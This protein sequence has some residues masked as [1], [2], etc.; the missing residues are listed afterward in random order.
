MN[1]WTVSER[2]FEHMQR[3]KSVAKRWACSC[4][5]SLGTTSDPQATAIS[6]CTTAPHHCI[7]HL[8][9]EGLVLRVAAEV[10]VLHLKRADH[11]A[12]DGEVDLDERVEK[13]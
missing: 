10:A 4:A 11:K 5:P 7:T 12:K 13:A 8:G 6:R 3:R 1:V 2:R 9:D